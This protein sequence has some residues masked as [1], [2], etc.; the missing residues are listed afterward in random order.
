M[1]IELQ[2]SSIWILVLVLIFF[3]F[4]L[5]CH[6]FLNHLQI[7]SDRRDTVSSAPET[8][9]TQ[10]F[11]LGVPWMN[12]DGW[13]SFET[14]ECVTHRILGR[15]SHNH[16]NV[17]RSN[18]AFHDFHSE[19]SCKIMH[20]LSDFNSNSLKKKRFAIFWYYHNMVRTI[21]LNMSLLVIDVCGHMIGRLYAPFSFQPLSWSLR[22]F[23]GKVE[24]I[25]VHQQSWRFS[26]LN[27]RWK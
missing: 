4:P 26:N 15:N 5:V 10:C 20:K 16:V 2:L 25:G 1:K 8:F 23:A 19:S 22:L 24:P 7:Y 18:I 11:L 27:Y 12:D 3:M 6:I 9:L 21:P 17:I 13:F 14:S